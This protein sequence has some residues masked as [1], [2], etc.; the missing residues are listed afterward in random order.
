LAYTLVDVDGEVSGETLAKV[1]SIDGVLA[2][3]VV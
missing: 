1:R 2:A 3:R